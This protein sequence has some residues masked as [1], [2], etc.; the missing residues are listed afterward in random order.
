MPSETDSPEGRATIDDLAEV[1]GSD[2]EINRAIRNFFHPEVRRL[3]PIDFELIMTLVKAG[4]PTDRQ[5]DDESA[6]D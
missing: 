4:H 2:P 5:P 6:A 1:L 3:D